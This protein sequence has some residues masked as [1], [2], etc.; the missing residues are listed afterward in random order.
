MLGAFGR[1]RRDEFEVDD[2]GYER[3][4]E[5]VEQWRAIAVELAHRLEMEHGRDL[6]AGPEL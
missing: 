5:Q 4:V 2:P 3:L 6:D 1:L